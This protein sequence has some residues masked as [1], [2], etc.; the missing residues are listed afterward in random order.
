MRRFLLFFLVAASFCLNGQ[1]LANADAIFSNTVIVV[2]FT[3]T[4]GQTCSGYSILYTADSTQPFQEIYPFSGVCGDPSQALDYSYQHT[5]FVANQVNYYKVRLQ[6]SSEESPVIRVW[7]SAR[8]ESGLFMYPNPSG[9][10]DAFLNMRLLGTDNTRLSG[11]LYNRFGTVHRHLEFET[12]GNQSS[13]PISDLGQGVY[14]IWLT[15]GESVFSG[16]FIVVR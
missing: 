13:L 6:P 2:R 1:R 5:G 14:V 7:A 15:D 10:N 11:F 16:K 3:I 4:A 8:A 12:T 9:V